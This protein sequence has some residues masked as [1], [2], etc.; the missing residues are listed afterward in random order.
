MKK[1]ILINLMCFLLF[2]S[3]KRAEP[4]P[5]PLQIIIK[6]GEAKSLEVD[7]E[8]IQIKLVD[9]ESVFSHGVLHAAGDAFKEETF[10]LD[11]I[12]DATVSIGIDTLRFRTM[13]TEINNQSPKEKT[14]EDLAKRPEID[15]KAYKSYQIGISN[16]YSELNSDSSRGYVVKLLIKK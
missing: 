16:M 15:I 7:E 13:F 11:R 1:L 10:V 9:V 6:E 2:F 8:V 12:Y 14:W 3:C 4:E 5:G